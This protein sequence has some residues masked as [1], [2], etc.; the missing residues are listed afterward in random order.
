MVATVIF[1]DSWQQI[2]TKRKK[3]TMQYLLNDTT[4]IQW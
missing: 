1:V 3:A 2:S 4:E